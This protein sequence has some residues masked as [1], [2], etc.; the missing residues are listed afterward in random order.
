MS[1]LNSAG[2]AESLN[3]YCIGVYNN[4]ITGTRSRR[5][6]KANSARSGID[7]REQ[8][9]EDE[10]PRLLVNACIHTSHRF[11]YITFWGISGSRLSSFLTISRRV[12]PEVEF[13]RVCVDTIFQLS[14]SR[15]FLSARL[16]LLQ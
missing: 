14:S 3:A 4:E 6:S 1:C 9:L 2:Q 11:T 10:L 7:K 13:L 8:L 16:I 15:S 5:D 12:T